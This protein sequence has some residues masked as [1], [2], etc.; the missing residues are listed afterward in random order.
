MN[1]LLLNWKD[2]KHPK[3][4]GAELIVHYF[5]RELV[6]AGHDVTLFCSA[7]ENCEA[8]TVID[9]VK[10]VRRGSLFTVFWHAFRYYKKLAQKPDLVVEH[11]NTIG[12]MTPLYV[13]QAQRR[14]YL[15]QLAQE[16]WSYEFPWPFSWIGYVVERLQYFLYQ[17]TLF[18]CYSDSTKSDLISYGVPAKNIHQFRLGLDHQRY[19]TGKKKA[20]HPLFLFVARLVNMKRPVRCF[21][22]FIKVL[23]THPTAELIFVGQGPEQ[24]TLQELITTL[25]VEKNVKL[26]SNAFFV[27]KKIQDPKVTY[28]QE[29]WALLLPSVK[30]GWG[31]VVTEA[32]A[33]GTPAIVS[34]VSGLRDSVVANKTGLVLSADP[35]ID[36]LAQAMDKLI[37]NEALRKKLN[38]EAVKW[39]A[40]FSWEDSYTSYVQAI[41]LD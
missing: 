37:E 3:V 18:L 40:N 30:E 13:P 27:D 20:D 10:I 25:D 16:V 26:V 19:V 11:I 36:E 23:A 38:N 1:V 7:F 33:C 5:A 35:S 39:A 17:T 22:A 31:M 6:K 8:E 9:G 32:A 2:V 28:M 4:G 21:E 15:N 14:A 24:A 41:G 12:W 29:A 34:N